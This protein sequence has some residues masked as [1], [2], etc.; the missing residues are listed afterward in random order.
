[1]N[2]SEVSI[3]DYSDDEFECNLSKVRNSLQISSLKRKKAD[4]AAAGNSPIYPSR[5][6]SAHSRYFK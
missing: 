1:M 2:V 6:G 4:I 5:F 3:T